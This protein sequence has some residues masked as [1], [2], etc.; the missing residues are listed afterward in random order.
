MLGADQKRWLKG[1]TKASDATWKVLAN[2]VMMMGLDQPAPGSPK[3]DDTW[4]GYAAERR[5]LDETS[6]S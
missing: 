3:F 1:V 4:D 5:E 2:G 6:S